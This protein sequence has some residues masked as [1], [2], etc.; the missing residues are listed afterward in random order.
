MAKILNMIQELKAEGE[1]QKPEKSLNTNKE[2][3]N[4]NDTQRLALDETQI[5]VELS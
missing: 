2:T 3:K 1:K 4:S 5:N